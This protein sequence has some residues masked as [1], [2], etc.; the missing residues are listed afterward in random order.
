MTQVT[1]KIDLREMENTN[2]VDAWIPPDEWSSI[3]QDFGDTI[4]PDLREQVEKHMNWRVSQMEGERNAERLEA[5]RKRAK[6]LKD[7][8][9]EVDK[10]VRALVE[11]MAKQSDGADISIIAEFNRCY[12]KLFDPSGGYVDYLKDNVSEAVS[13]ESKGIRNKE[14]WREVINQLERCDGSPPDR[15]GST[16]REIE[17]NYLGLVS[18]S[19]EADDRNHGAGNDGSVYPFMRAI[20]AIDKHFPKSYRPNRDSDYYLARSINEA[21]S[22]LRSLEDL[23]SE[24]LRDQPQP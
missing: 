11:E 1:P 2:S 24:N 5:T 6:S 20:R 13:W 9:A 16:I 21:R 4:P 12:A 15:R 18:R 7:K 19:F 17:L 23:K 8:C 10:A 3:E 22:L 14:T